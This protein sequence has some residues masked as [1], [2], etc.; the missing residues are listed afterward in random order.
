[1]NHIAIAVVAAAVPHHSPVTKHTTATPRH[2]RTYAHLRRRVI[3]RYGVRTPG[4][5]IVADGLSNGRA[6]TDRAVTRSTNVL[7]RMLQPTRHT[8]S[9]SSGTQTAVPVAAST[10]AAPTSGLES[11]IIQAESGGDST[12]VNSSGHMGLGQWDESTWIADGGQQYGATPLDATA[13]EQEQIIAEQIAAG[14]TSQW[15][16]YDGC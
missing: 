6:S 10:T 4:R 14:N 5:N 2:R 15:T 11:C 13:A 3:R 16:N 8:V 1:M 7:R 12:V 9:T